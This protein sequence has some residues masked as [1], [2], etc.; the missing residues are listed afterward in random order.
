V[1]VSKF[2][3]IDASICSVAFSPRSQRNHQ[4]QRL[5]GQTC[6]VGMTLG[7]SNLSTQR[8]GAVVGLY[9]ESNDYD[10][11]S[12]SVSSTVNGFI[13][14]AHGLD[15]GGVY[16]LA[17]LNSSDVPTPTA[18]R[19]EAFFVDKGFPYWRAGQNGRGNTASSLTVGLES[20]PANFRVINRNSWTLNLNA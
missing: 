16:H 5:S 12:T 8:S 7:I 18:E 14:A 15:W 10:G 9:L 13:A 3:T 11:I 1:E 4:V 19:I 6:G 2:E 17:A 20:R